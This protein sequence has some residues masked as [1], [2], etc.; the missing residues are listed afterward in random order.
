MLLSSVLAISIGSAIAYDQLSGALDAATYT[1]VATFKVKDGQVERFVEEM[2]KNEAASRLESGVVVYRSYQDTKNPNLFVNYETY[3]NED[4]FNTH[5]ETDHVQALLPIL[6]EI[7]DGPI[8]IQV[9]ND[10]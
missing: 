6:E 1:I 4:A 10:Y 9:L 3:V 2:Q 5:V 7:L 8:D